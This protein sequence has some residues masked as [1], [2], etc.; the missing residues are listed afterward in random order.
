MQEQH[1]A[2]KLRALAVSIFTQGTDFYSASSFLLYLTIDM[3]VTAVQS[4]HDVALYLKYTHGIEVFGLLNTD[5]LE[6]LR[7]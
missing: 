4:K 1:Y 3:M 2:H 5:D 6:V 7:Q